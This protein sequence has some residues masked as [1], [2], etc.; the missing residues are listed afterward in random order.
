MLIAGILDRQV[1]KLTVGMNDASG[2]NDFFYERYQ[3]L[4]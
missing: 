1:A 3:A 4:G 2:L